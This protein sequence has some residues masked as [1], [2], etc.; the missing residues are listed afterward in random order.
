MDTASNKRHSLPF[1]RRLFLS[2]LL[3]FVAF[4]ACFIGFQYKREKEYKIERLN[5]SLQ[6]YN[7][8]LANAISRGEDVDGFIAANRQEDSVR[9]TIIDSSGKVTFDSQHDRPLSEFVNHSDRPEFMEALKY[10]QGYTLRRLSETT[11]KY[12]FYSATCADGEVIRS[13]VHYSLTLREVLRADQKFLWFMLAIALIICVAA[14]ML[15]WRLGDNITRLQKFAVKA[16]KGEPIDDI[17]EFPKD[18]L[19]EI[20]NHI[21]RLY[22]KLRE[23]KEALENEHNVVIK[24]EQDQVR[25]KR[26]LT[27]NINHELKTPV[28]GIMGY[29]ETIIDNPGMSTE[30]RNDFIDK[31]YSQ[32]QRLSR[33]LKDV[34]TITRMDEASEMIEKEPISLSDLIREIFDEMAIQIE[35]KGVRVVYNVM[36]GITMTGNQSLLSSIFRNLIDNSLAYSGCTTIFISAGEEKDGLINVTFSDDGIGIAE[37][38]LPRIFERFYRVDKGRSRK[39]G[40]TGLGLS[41]VKNAVVLHGGSIVAR[42]REGGGLEFLF[43]LKSQS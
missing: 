41:I 24:Q 33:L 7:L 22:T 19:G 11:N 31:S 12:Y 1:N 6:L 20:S 43:T 2:L 3:L 8:R 16:D 18:E 34:A 14:Y 35:N 13:A 21:V 42:Q 10:G 40:G 30:Q 32:V 5:Y 4:L 15:T 36:D 29:L 23:T 37:E 26:Q 38:H 39:M 28:S 9:V 25:L 27:Q 17:G